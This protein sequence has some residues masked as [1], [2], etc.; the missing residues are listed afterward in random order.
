MSKPICVILKINAIYMLH[1]QMV[2]G[3]KVHSKNFLGNFLVDKNLPKNRTRKFPWKSK[4]P[5]KRPRKFP[6][7][8]KLP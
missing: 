7:K 6:W 8:S 4:L 5:R 3:K 1:C 2:Y